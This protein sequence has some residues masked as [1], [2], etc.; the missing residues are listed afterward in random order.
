[1]QG[2]EPVGGSTSTADTSVA[3]TSEFSSIPA[4][5]P[6]TGYSAPPPPPTAGGTATADPLAGTD[7]PAETPVYPAGGPTP[8]GTL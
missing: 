5:P 3:A 7:A 4:P 2:R 6:T 1:V 8:G